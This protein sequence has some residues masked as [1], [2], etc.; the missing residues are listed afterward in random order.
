MLLGVWATKTKTSSCSHA[1]SWVCV[2]RF[3][4]ALYWRIESSWTQLHSLSM[5]CLIAWPKARWRLCTAECQEGDK[6]CLEAFPLSLQSRLSLTGQCAL[7][8]VLKR[9]VSPK[10]LTCLVVLGFSCSGQCCCVRKQVSTVLQAVICCWLVKWRV[11]GTE[12]IQNSIRSLIGN[13]AAFY[14]VLC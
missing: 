2:W 11:T 13:R 8:Q 9:A 1:G 14:P 5:W 12:A 3:R 4:C 10:L 7:G 6:E